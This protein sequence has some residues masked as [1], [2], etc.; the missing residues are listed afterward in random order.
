MEQARHEAE[1][2]LGQLT[3][4]SRLE[5][6]LNER[7]M[8][9]E[10]QERFL[11]SIDARARGMPLQYLLGE[12]VFHG[13]PFAVSPDV[14]IPRPETESVVEAAMAALR[15]RQARLDRPLRLLDIGTGTGCIAVT[16]AHGLAACVVVAV[17]LSWNA[18]QVARANIERHE[19]SARVQ[20]V[21]ARW[22]EAIR[23]AFDGIISNPPY[24]PSARVDH[25]PLDVRH[26]PRMSLDGGPDGMEGLSHL[27]EQAGGLLVPEGILALESE[28]D[29]VPRL[30]ELARATPWVEH[31]SP[32]E[33]LTRRPRGVLLTKH[34]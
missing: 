23:G 18:L 22:V 32:L 4:A 10:T 21:Q 8:S 7:S 17:E 15:S 34:E 30:I 27:V 20:L 33:D 31:A 28:E 26:E 5:L 24:V 19:L 1:W 2:L 9:V 29:H 6:Y 16:L 12:A 25:V 13:R 11:S 14:F 3:G